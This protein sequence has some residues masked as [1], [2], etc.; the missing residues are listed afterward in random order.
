MRMIYGNSFT[1][2]S[3]KQTSGALST[4]EAESMPMSECARDI[5]EVRKLH[6]ELEFDVIDDVVIR[7][8][9]NAASDLSS[10]VRSIRDPRQLDIYYID[11]SFI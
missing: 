6:A 5:K 8:N 1:R 9:N 7:A 11:R 10:S 3:R 4:S 2:S